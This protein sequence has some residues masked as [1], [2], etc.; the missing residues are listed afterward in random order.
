VRGTGGA[1]RRAARGRASWPRN[2]A[3]CASAHSPVHGGR[4]EGRSNREGPRRGEREERGARGNGSATDDPGP[5]GR[6]RRS[7][8]VKKPA[9]TGRPQ[10]A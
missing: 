8:R 10:W 3:T 6:E 5:R 1:L 7:T 4:R 2:L 9:L